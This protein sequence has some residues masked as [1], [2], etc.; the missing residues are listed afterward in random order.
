MTDRQYEQTK[1]WNETIYEAKDRLSKEFD[2]LP[3]EDNFSELNAEYQEKY[4][5]MNI[6]EKWSKNPLEE[7]TDEEFEEKLEELKKFLA[8]I[9][10]LR[11][12]EEETVLNSE[13]NSQIPYWKTIEYKNFIA[14]GGT[15]QDYILQLMTKRNI[16]A[17]KC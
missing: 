2:S 3:D 14:N 4:E 6:Y 16:K 17:I 8:T 12:N 15:H 13:N 10:M 7:M 5:M 1:K 11:N 9:T